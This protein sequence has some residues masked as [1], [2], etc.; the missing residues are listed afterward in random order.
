MSG[1]LLGQQIAIATARPQYG[2]AAF[3]NLN[4]KDELLASYLDVPFR[5]SNVSNVLTVAANSVQRK[6]SDGLGNGNSAV[7]SFK[8][9]PAPLTQFTAIASSTL[10]LADGSITGAFSAPTSP[11]VTANHYI[12]MGVELRTDNQLHVVFGTANAVSGS[13][14][15]V[16]FS[17]DAVQKVFETLLQKNGVTGT[18]GF[19][20]TEANSYVYLSSGSGSGG[21]SGGINPV[22]E[23]A[24]TYT[25]KKGFIT[26]YSRSIELAADITGV[27]AT[28]A[29]NTTYYVYLDI[30]AVAANSYVI[31]SAHFF[32][33]TSAPE[34]GLI[35]LNKYLPRGQYTVVAGVVDSASLKTHPDNNFGDILSTFPLAVERAS[36]AVS[37]ATT[38]S[39]SHLLSA[40]PTDFEIFFFENS[41]GNTTVVPASSVITNFTSTTVYYDTTAFTF[42]AGDSLTILAKY[43]P[44][45]D[46]VI[47]MPKTSFASNLL[48]DGSVTTIAHGLGSGIISAVAVQTDVIA[49]RRK[50]LFIPNSP[51]LNFDDTN[52]YLDWTGFSPSST[53]T[54][55]I[56]ASTVNGLPAALSI[57]GFFA[58]AQAADANTTLL[59]TSNDAQ[60]FNISASRDVTL[61]TTSVKAGRVF[62]ITNRGAFNL[63][64]KASNGNALTIANSC[65]MDATIQNGRVIVRALQDTPT[66]PAHWHVDYV[67]E[68]DVSFTVTL[69]GMTASTTGTAKF[70][71]TNKIVALFLPELT[72]TSNTTA[73]TATGLPTRIATAYAAELPTAVRDNGTNGFGWAESGN[74]STTLTFY[75]GV[76][77][78]TFTGSGSKGLLGS[79]LSYESI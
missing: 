42:N 58:G 41:S 77:F 26:Y 74:N 21:S 36:Q 61:P 28:V 53:E 54:Y 37:T 29:S 65:N 51:V 69:T 47:V 17:T 79:I 73:M 7:N 22:Y 34:S 56:F 1:E 75:N 6:K 59:N 18:W 43:E 63:V 20:Y 10:D 25:V 45:A 15:R 33:S 68:T 60:N 12:W 50:S 2:S 38:G 16:T 8:V 35:N 78:G 5:L 64:V 71:R 70:S 46:T 23:S 30:N 31:T 27:T 52:I 49:S 32:N 48:T 44:P 55:Q 72:G 9:A 19:N 3:D 67:N 40:A 24:T 14:T 11:S 39:F 66:T 57:F 62:T 4:T 76:G 13:A